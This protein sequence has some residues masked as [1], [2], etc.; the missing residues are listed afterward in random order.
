MSVSDF[1]WAGIITKVVAAIIILVVT[2]LIA[3]IV[4]SALSKLLGKVKALSGRSDDGQ[5][6]ADSLASVGSL[7]VWLFGLIAVLNVFELTSAVS[8]LQK[9]VGGVLGFVPQIIAAG[10]IMFIGIVLAKVARQL[11]VTAL[12]AA[13]VDRHASKL[14]SKASEEVSAG[15]GGDVTPGQPG[16]QPGAPGAPGAGSGS[17]GPKISEMVGQLVF[18]IVVIVMA[19]AALQALDIKAISGPAVNML[20]IILQA[21]PNVLAAVILLVIGVVIAKLIAS[22]VE[23]LLRGINFDGALSS[24]G[25]DS[26]DKDVPGILTKCVQIAIVLFFAI[27]AANMLRF[28]QI[29]DILNTILALAGHIAFGGVIIIAGVLIANVL[30]KLVGSGTTATITRFAVIA[31]FAAVGLRYMGLANSIIN[32]AFGALVIGAAAAGVLAFGLGG[33]DAAAR[34]LEKMRESGSSD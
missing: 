24:M 30:A 28:P 15:V 7:I 31:L 21:I 5:T 6:T 12:Q 27:A 4:K 18:G 10:L 1:D 17:G 11:V 34:Q 16:G 20:H 26:Q 3:K 22:L 19:I 29:T 23:S 32:M 9:L 14:G 8:S 13:N 2:W 33:R 25:I